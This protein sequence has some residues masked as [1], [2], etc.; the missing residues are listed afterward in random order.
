MPESALTLDA[1]VHVVAAALRHTRTVTGFLGATAERAP[2]AVG[3]LLLAGDRVPFAVGA[4]DAG[5]AGGESDA[6][7][8]VLRA[9]E[10]G[11]RLRLDSPEVGGSALLEFAPQ[12]R[13]TGNRS[14]CEVHLAGESVPEWLYGRVSAYLAAVREL[15]AEWASG[16]VVVGTALVEDGMLLAQQRRYPAHHAGSWELPGGRVEPGEGEPEAVVRECREELATEVVPL[17]RVG[18]DIPL[19]ADSGMLLR[20][21]RARLAVGAR[22]PVPVEHRALRW[23]E[24]SR[25]AELEWLEAD[26]LLLD[27]LWAIMVAEGAKH[28]PK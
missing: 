20:V 6:T 14:R 19:S 2:E 27:S 10:A 9:D 3:E 16:P 11:L 23:I 7:G 13:A 15:V 17:G 25:L 28:D 5:D 18:T 22:S 26:R 4:G 8:T 24:L 21:W 1:P 12:E